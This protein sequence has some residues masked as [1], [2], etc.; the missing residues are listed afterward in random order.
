M[1][2]EGGDDGLPRDVSQYVC[3]SSA[4]VALATGV[5]RKSLPVSRNERVSELSRAMLSLY[6]PLR[7]CR[8]TGFEVTLEK[9][10]RRCFPRVLSYCCDVPQ[11]RDLSSI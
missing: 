3:T 4:V 10:A 11:A 1:W 8:E 5:L 9:G 2:V 7:K 6:E